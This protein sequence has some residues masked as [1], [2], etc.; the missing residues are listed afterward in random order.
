MG[1]STAS[2][3]PSSSRDGFHNPPLRNVKASPIRATPKQSASS[4]KVYAVSNN[5]D[6]KRLLSRQL[7]GGYVVHSL[8]HAENCDAER[9]DLLLRLPLSCYFSISFLFRQGGWLFVVVSR[10]CV[11]IKARPL[12]I[13]GQSYRTR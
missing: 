13:K 3:K 7:S 10:A 2:K 12:T 9:G 6:H 4:I 11:V 8:S 1:K 5:H